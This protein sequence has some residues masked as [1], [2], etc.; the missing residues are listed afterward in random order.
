VNRTVTIN[1]FSRPTIHGTKLVEMG[2]T[3][4]LPVA[5]TENS[6][7]VTGDKEMYLV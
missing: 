5:N 2:L 6:C 3:D 4:I 1:A 7:N